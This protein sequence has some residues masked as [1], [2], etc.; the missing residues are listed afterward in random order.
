VPRRRPA[1]AD[2]LEQEIEAALQP[3]FFIKYRAGSA[4]VEDLD[5]VEE[6]IAKLVRSAPARAVALYETFLAGCY[7]KAEELDG[8][9]GNFGMFVAGLFR[10]WVKAC[11]A[12]GADPDGTARRLVTWMEDDAYGFCHQIERDLVKVLEKRG[13]AAFERRIRERFDGVATAAPGPGERQR[14][15]AYL[16]RRA[17]EILRAILAAQRNVDAYVALCEATELSPADCL[18]LAK[19]LQARRKP[20]DALAWVERGLALEKKFSMSFAGHDLGK[21]RRDLLLKLG[22]GDAA[23]EAAWADFKTDPSIYSY[24]DLM[25]CVP[26]AERAAWHQKAMD[27]AGSAELDSVI[28]LW[29]E[30]KEIDRLIERLRQAH[31]EELEGMSHH[32][33][34]PVAR[35]L[36]KTHPDVAAKVYRALGM[37]ILKAKKSKYYGAALS[38]FED[39]RRC[40]ER[41]GLGP[42]WESLVREVRAEHHRK[43][44]FMSGFGEVVAGGGPSAKPTF[45]QRAKARWSNS[46]RG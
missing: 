42:Q 40:Y 44:G 23:L 2:P 9:S 17:A 35:K 30:T 5:C 6:K 27:E 37:R 15:P 10:G 24:S 36:A 12:A 26:K 31:D 8:S 33:T 7:E 1:K 45:L 16:R 28:E 18:A 22:R 21:L 34:E 20:V 39:A 11:Q 41:A 25:R 14:D 46:P 3:G 43:T 4:F 29:L 13:L 32:A 19:V 38:S